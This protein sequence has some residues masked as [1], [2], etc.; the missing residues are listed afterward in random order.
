MANAD[1]P[2]ATMAYGMA[3]PLNLMPRMR[4]VRLIRAEHIEISSLGIPAQADGDAA[5]AGPVVVHDAP[6]PMN[7]VVG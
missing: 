7:V 3:L 1:G 6:S 5:G 4:G 2:L